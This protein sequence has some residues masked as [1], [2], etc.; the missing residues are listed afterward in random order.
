MTIEKKLN[1]GYV[2]VEEKF[3]RQ[4]GV[5]RAI[6]K[7]REYQDIKHGFGG[8][9]LGTW[10]LLIKA[11]LDEVE[12]AIIK[13]GSGRDAVAAELIQVAAL[14]VAALQQHGLEEF[15]GRRL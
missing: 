5:I 3:D 14:C 9:E 15:P 2:S 7:E 8:H 10:F 13:G 11:E 4:Q 12:H 1:N 6:L